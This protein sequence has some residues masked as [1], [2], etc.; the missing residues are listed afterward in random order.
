VQLRLHYATI[1][2]RAQS[3]YRYHTITG[4]NVPYRFIP[5]LLNVSEISNF[6][7][8]YTAICHENFITPSATTDTLL[9]ALPDYIQYMF[10]RSFNRKGISGYNDIST[11]LK[12]STPLPG[13]EQHLITA[14]K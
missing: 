13:R 10:Y 3:L 12:Q 14:D 9:Y 2:W 8:S 1:P 5:Q 11:R 4:N 7:P 6:V